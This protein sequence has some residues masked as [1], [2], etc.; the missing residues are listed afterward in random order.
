MA[1]DAHNCTWI[2]R[3][4]A[5][6]GLMLAQRRKLY[7]KHDKS[8]LGGLLVYSINWHNSLACLVTNNW[9]QIKK[10]GTLIAILYLMLNIE[11]LLVHLF[12]NLFAVF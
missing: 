9:K 1:L 2:K 11:S 7:Y 10:K 4:L 3:R 8:T 5:D 12:F 6:A